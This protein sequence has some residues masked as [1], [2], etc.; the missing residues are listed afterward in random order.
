MSTSQ[1]AQ[2]HIY[3]IA[4]LTVKEISFHGENNFYLLIQSLPI[5]TAP[6]HALCTHLSEKRRQQRRKFQEAL[7]R[8]VSTLTIATTSASPGS[9]QPSCKP[10]VALPTQRAPREPWE[11][12]CRCASCPL[13]PSCFSNSL[14]MYISTGLIWRCREAITFSA[15]GFWYLC[16]Y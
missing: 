3:S 9:C 14:I 12:A 10:A 15:V 1:T 11:G 16:S 8:Q 4:R 6:R 2:I 5:T 7:P 13:P